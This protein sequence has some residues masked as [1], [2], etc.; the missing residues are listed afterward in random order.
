MLYYFDFYFILDK[1]HR[2]CDVIDNRV[3]LVSFCVI[4]IDI[5]KV[6]FLFM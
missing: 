3:N 5:V 2:Q 6:T 1:S 4:I